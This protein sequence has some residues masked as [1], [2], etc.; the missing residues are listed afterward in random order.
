MTMTT[1]VYLKKMHEI[2]DSTN[3]RKHLNS[4]SAVVLERIARGGGATNWYFINNYKSLE[5]VEEKLKPGSVVSFYFDDRIIS[6]QYSEELNSKVADIIASKG[7]CVIGSLKVGSVNIDVDFI[8]GIGELTDFV[9][10][11]DSSSL[12]FYGAFP[13]RENDGDSAIT[14]VL[15]D[16]DGSVRAHPH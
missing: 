16:I 10:S 6:G 7:D 2:F 3:L 12:F 4:R 9:L 13:A 15:P 1:N 8:T 11:L 5:L 14:L